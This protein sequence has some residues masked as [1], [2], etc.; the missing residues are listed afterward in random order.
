MKNFN[1]AVEQYKSLTDDE[2]FILIDAL[3]RESRD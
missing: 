2:Q 3:N 1:K